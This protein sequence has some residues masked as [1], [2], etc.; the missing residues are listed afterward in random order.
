M[1]AR[2][3]GRRFIGTLEVVVEGEVV[4]VHVPARADG[5]GAAGFAGKGY[6]VGGFGLLLFGVVV[7]ARGGDVVVVRATRL[8][9]DDAAA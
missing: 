8:F 3:L 9:A 7:Q 1:S 5:F 2:C 6:R 4:G